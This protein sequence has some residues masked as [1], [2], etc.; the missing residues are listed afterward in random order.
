MKK[1]SY[2]LA[3]VLFAIMC[4]NSCKGPGVKKSTSVEVISKDD[5]NVIENAHDAGEIVFK[6]NC[7]ACHQL[8]AK[9][10]PGIYPPIVNTKKMKGEKKYLI[11]VILNG[12]KGE[13]EVDG[14]KYNGLMASYRNLS[15]QEIADVLNY[16]RKD[17]EEEHEIV[18][19]EDVKGYR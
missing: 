13:I 19:A 8:N 6:Q 18:S 14:K 17:I 11:S 4:M 3:Y 2:L 1:K 16:L 12:L 7:A 5:Q 15:D 10:I 9:G